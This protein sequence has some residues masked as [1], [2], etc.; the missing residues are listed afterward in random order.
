MAETT[1]ESHP[2]T[3]LSGREI[4]QAAGVVMAGFILSR[5]LG[6][7]LDVLAAGIFGGS[8]LWDAFVAA[9]RPPDTLFTV[10]AGG[11]LG[12]AFIPTFIG[13]FVKNEPGRAWRLASSVTNAFFLLMAVLSVLAATF[14]LPLVHFVLAPSF[15]EQQVALT[16]HLV[17]IMMLTPAIFT[18]SGLLMGVLNARQ[19]FLLP[20]LAPGLY[21]VGIILGILLLSPIMGIDG[22]AWG[23]V[24]GALLHLLI[25]LPG[26]I[27]LR[28]VYRPVVDAGDPGFWEVIRLM[29]PRV[30]G[31]AV[32]QVNFWVELILAS[33][34]AE[35]SI[36]ALRRGFMVMLMPQAVIAQSVAIAVFP[37][38]SVQVASGDQGQLRRTLG[39][40]LRVVLFLSLP[41]SVGLILL[42]LPIIQVLYERQAFTTEDS[43]AVAWALL[44]YG[45]GLVSHSLLE[46]VTRAYYAMH[47]TRTPVAV[48]GGA[49]L[50]NIVFSL[51]LMHVVGTPGSLVA[52]P[53][54]GLALANTLATTVE[55][56]ALLALIIPRLR[57]EE[58]PGETH[59][60]P[61]RAAVSAGKTII[62][63]AAMGL[64]VWLAVPILPAGGQALAG[65]TLAAVAGGGALYW[66]V[67]WGLGSDEARLLTAFALQRLGLGKADR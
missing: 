32:V 37:T 55:V 63:S 10:I 39:Q 8:A 29:G 35:G 59:V 16:A 19:H 7:A 34:M 47:D 14:A 49:M 13:Y 44:F 23:T 62:A 57:L 52:G 1:S 22:A 60:S 61:L 50:L 30:L 17:Q 18:V 27:G 28:P 9:S 4:A 24:I 48:G 64:G 12:S 54:G 20:A 42:R 67:A 31:L 45:L 65:A 53:F 3:A 6:L 46:V 38:F 5:V 66:G 36:S 2:T 58:R 56:G 51:I 41:A 15:D 11:A 33:G 21:N 26:L 40:V 43:Q 25:Q